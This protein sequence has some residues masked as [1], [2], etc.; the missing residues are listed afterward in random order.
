MP[1]ACETVLTTPE[2]FEIILLHFHLRDLLQAQR[3]NRTFNAMITNSPSVQRA[4]FFRGKSTEVI[5]P[6]AHDQIGHQ[7]VTWEQNSLLCQAFPAWFRM[8]PS[9]LHWIGKRNYK[10][11]FDHLDWNSSE[12]RRRAYARREA[13]WRRM[14]VVQPPT[15][16]LEVRGHIHA[17]GGDRERTGKVI[18]NDGVTMGLLYDI[19]ESFFMGGRSSNSFWLE[20]HMFP[21]PSRNSDG[22]EDN[23]SNRANSNN[24]NLTVQPA[25]SD[26]GNDGFHSR[27][28]ITLFLLHIVSCERD[29]Y[30]SLSR[31]KSDA[32]EV[33][34]IDY[35]E[36]RA[37]PRW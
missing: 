15:T 31:L 8:L 32:A 2:L 6:E 1:T 12:E 33:V 21:E 20:W 34:D 27:S 26:S 37:C 4:L 5:A 22:S 24:I 23:N 29:P 16:L 17:M 36:W 25:K 28:W 7:S 19:V 30:N 13:S 3:V 35:T 18:L 11:T 14:L 10:D 9:S